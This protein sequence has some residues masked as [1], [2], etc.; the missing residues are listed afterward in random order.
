[1]FE[2][3]D[4][5]MLY[6]LFCCCDFGTNLVFCSCLFVF[7]FNID[8]FGGEKISMLTSF[9]VDYEFELQSDQANDNT[10]TICCFSTKHMTL[11]SKNK[12]WLDQT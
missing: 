5:A 10:I 7:S 6:C 2:K 3:D 9:A 11:G 1:M 8:R 12:D 4:I